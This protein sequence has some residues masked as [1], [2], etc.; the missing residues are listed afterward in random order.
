VNRPTWQF[1]GVAL[2]A[3]MPVRLPERAAH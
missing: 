3:I 1:F 2:A